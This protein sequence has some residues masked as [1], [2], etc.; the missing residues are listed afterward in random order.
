[1]YNEYNILKANISYYDTK[2][3]YP[4]FIDDVDNDKIRNIPSNP[5]KEGYEFLGWYKDKNLEKQIDFR[6]ENIPK[7]LYDK[8]GNYIYNEFKIFVKWKNILTGEIYEY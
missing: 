2:D 3:S 7:K 5:I 4:Y 1:M 8:D 6:L